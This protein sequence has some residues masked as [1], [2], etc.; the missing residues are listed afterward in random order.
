MIP[1]LADIP[2]AISTEGKH[3]MGNDA[4]RFDTHSQTG[5]LGPEPDSPPSGPPETG[6]DTSHQGDRQ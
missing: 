5:S 3:E 2:W 1:N 4:K 6:G